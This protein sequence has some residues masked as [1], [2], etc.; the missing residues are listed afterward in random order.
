MATG[1][2]TAVVACVVISGLCMSCRNS[3]AR[4]RIENDGSASF[5]NLTVMFPK[6]QIGFGPIAAGATTAYRE[7]AHGVGRDASFRF[8]VNGQATEQFVV[9]FVGW[10]PMKGKA[11]TYR[12]R[13]E[14]GRSQ[15]LLNVLSVHKDE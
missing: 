10:T 1:R 15:P 13:I 7:V 14:P 9:D 11:F 3:K 12:V 8:V 5:E 4:L 6:D 2:L